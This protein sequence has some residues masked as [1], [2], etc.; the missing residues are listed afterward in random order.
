MAH[1]HISNANV[2]AHNYQGSAL[3]KHLASPSNPIK[4]YWCTLSWVSEICLSIT[5]CAFTLSKCSPGEA[6]W[7][8]G[9]FRKWEIQGG[10]INILKRGSRWEIFHCC[11]LNVTWSCKENRFYCCTL[12]SEKPCA[13]SVPLRPISI[14]CQ[15][16]HHTFAKWIN[17]QSAQR[18]SLPVVLVN[19]RYW[20]PRYGVLANRYYDDARFLWIDTLVSIHL[21]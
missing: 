5:S 21:Q 20:N 11:L 2:I 15:L 8:N 3:E 1:T 9:G 16:L 13:C 19:F 7:A 12:Q 6:S 14:T 18:S 4:C 17:N 10:G